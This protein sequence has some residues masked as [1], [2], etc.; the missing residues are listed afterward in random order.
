MLV[1]SSIYKQVAGHLREIPHPAHMVENSALKPDTILVIRP[2]LDS[3]ISNRVKQVQE[4]LWK[5]D[6]GWQKSSVK[7][8]QQ[9]SR[10]LY[11]V[12]RM[13]LLS[14]NIPGLDFSF[15]QQIFEL[16]GLIIKPY[17]TQSLPSNFNCSRERM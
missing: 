2:C 14:E 6:P 10:T 8:T 1:L 17:R 15:I 4:V 13:E 5:H 12:L 11:K 16:H 7:F 9:S 3:Q